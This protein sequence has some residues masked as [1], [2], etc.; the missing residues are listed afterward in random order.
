MGRVGRSHPSWGML[1]PGRPDHRRR[2]R[3][4]IRECSRR[5]NHLLQTAAQNAGRAVP[6]HWVIPAPPEPGVEPFRDG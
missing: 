5:G 4:A 2:A 6:P 3:Q 1:S